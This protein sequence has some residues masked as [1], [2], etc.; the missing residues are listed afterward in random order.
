MTYARGLLVVL[1]VAGGA[2][3]AGGN[4]KKAL[5]PFQGKWKIVRSLRGGRPAPAEKL[6]NAEVFIEGDA[7]VIA[8]GGKE[9][10]HFKIDAARTPH[11]IDILPDNAKKE[12]VQGI[13]RFDDKNKR[14]TIAYARHGEGPRP[15]EFTLPEGSNISVLELERKN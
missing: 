12:T 4:D 11:T 5:E 2:L 10:A 13:Y 9:A 14:L 6:A 7:I 8:G 3:A 1:L 15:T